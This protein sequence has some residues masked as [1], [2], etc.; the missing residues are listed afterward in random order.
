MYISPLHIATRRNSVELIDILLSNGANIIAIDKR[1]ATPLHFAIS[2]NLEESGQFLLQRLIT[3]HPEWLAEAD[4][5]YDAARGKS[6]PLLEQIILVSDFDINKPNYS[7]NTLLHIASEKG[8]VHIVKMLLRKDCNLNSLNKDNATPLG[9]AISK[10]SLDIAR[11]LIKS[12]ADVDSGGIPRTF[13]QRTHKASNV[14]GSL[15]YGAL[16]HNSQSLTHLL[17]EAGLNIHEQKWL[18]SV[19]GSFTNMNTDLKSYLLIKSCR[20]ESLQKIS[21]H[22]IRKHGGKRI[23]RLTSD[24]VTKVMKDYLLMKFT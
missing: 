22:V 17:L 6:L 23:V 15:L 9:I 19:I 4:L 20:P 8:H 1:G 24:D 13:F 5:A 16:F 21:R 7:G 14:N 12:G 11:L 3:S 18:P 2:G 10:N